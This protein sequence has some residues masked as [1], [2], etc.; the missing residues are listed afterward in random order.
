MLIFYSSLQASKRPRGRDGDRDGV[1]NEDGDAGGREVVAHLAKE[2][3]DD[4]LHDVDD[5]APAEVDAERDADEREHV[6]LGEIR[7]GRQQHGE[8]RERDVGGFGEFFAPALHVAGEE[9]R[10]EFDEAV[11]GE[12]LEDDGGGDEGEAGSESEANARDGVADADGEAEE[13]E[14]GDEDEDEEAIDFLRAG[15]KRGD[16]DLAVEECERDAGQGDA[17]EREDFAAIDFV[18]RDGEFHL[19]QTAAANGGSWGRRAAAQARR[20]GS[21]WARVCGGVRKARASGF[22]SSARQGG[23]ESETRGVSARVTAARGAS[24]ADKLKCAR[25]R[26]PSS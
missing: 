17:D 2:D 20:T 4:G 5:A 6:V 9:G 11:A 1:G 15:V 14:D 23:R 24:V 12:E 18:A 26:S 22:R 19:L 8:L 3:A 7:H 21:C 10:G 13:R 16:V 25:M